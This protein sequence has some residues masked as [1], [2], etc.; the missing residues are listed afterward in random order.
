MDEAADFA[1]PRGWH[2][3]NR[4][5]TDVD[6][7]MGFAT[8]LAMAFQGINFQPVPLTKQNMSTDIHITAQRY[9]ESEVNQDES[10]G[11]LPPREYRQDKMLK[12]IP[13]FYFGNVVGATEISVYILFPR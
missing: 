1:T 12:D 10:A 3:L 13:H 4:L 6:S 9:Q 5:A 7:F 2:V 8:S 11:E